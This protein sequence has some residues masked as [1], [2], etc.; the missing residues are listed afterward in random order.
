MNILKGMA[1]SAIILFLAASLQQSFAE[2][3]GIVPY[4]IPSIAVLGVVCWLGIELTAIRVEMQ[5]QKEAPAP[6]E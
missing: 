2:T 1:L 5:R 3:V 6:S 4:L